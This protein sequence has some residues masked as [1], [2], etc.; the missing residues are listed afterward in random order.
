[1]T[2]SGF[3]ASLKIGCR[4]CAV[5]NYYTTRP[6]GFLDL[7]VSSDLTISNATAVYDSSFLNNLYPGWRFPSALSST[8]VFVQNVALTDTAS[9]TFQLPIGNAGQAAN[10]N[11]ALKNVTVVLNRWMG[12]GSILPTVRGQGNE[13]SLAYRFQSNHARLMYAVKGDVRMTLQ[14]QPDT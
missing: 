11:M 5:S 14:A 2:I 9:G 3:A 4:S 1:D 7:L 13:L 10:K 12:A 6:D 8:N